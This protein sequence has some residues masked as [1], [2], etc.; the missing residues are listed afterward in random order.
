MA[1]TSVNDVIDVVTM[2]FIDSKEDI[3][4]GDN[5][6]K[7]DGSNLG[8]LED[9]GMIQNFSKWGNNYWVIVING[10]SA[11][12]ISRPIY[13]NHANI[14][15]ELKPIFNLPKLGTHKIKYER[16]TYLLIKARLNKE[17]TEIVEERNL[18]FVNDTDDISLI[19]KVQE[20]F[21]FRD[22]LGLT[23]SFEKSVILRIPYKEGYSPYPISFHDGNIKI[24][25]GK[26]STSSKVKEKWYGEESPSNICRRLFNLNFDDSQDKIEEKLLYVRTEIDKVIN[27]LDKKLVGLT[28]AIID[29]VSSNINF[30]IFDQEET[31]WEVGQ[32]SMEQIS[33][34][35]ENCT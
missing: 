3:P 32:L 9:E 10:Y 4:I 5:P 26:T 21:F 19:E 17:K 18:L 14:V 30:S 34:S 2:R 13:N 22:L 12:C 23:Q 28:Q 16:K 29:N 7:W 27:R 31:D 20:T 15:D 33:Q 1:D 35:L 24:R 6:F 8:K 11:I 25:N